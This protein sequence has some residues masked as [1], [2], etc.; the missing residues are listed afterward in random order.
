M[1]GS[2]DVPVYHTFFNTLIWLLTTGVT[3]IALEAFI[4]CVTRT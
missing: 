4:R 2:L 1:Y 3:Y